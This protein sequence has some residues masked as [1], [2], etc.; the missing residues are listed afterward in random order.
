[1]IFH[2]DDGALLEI[3]V[4]SNTS[5]ILSFS[6]KNLVRNKSACICLENKLENLENL[7]NFE[8]LKMRK[9]MIIWTLDIYN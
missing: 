9:K 2:V 3:K 7:K 4:M 5:Y 1:M 8:N 6:P